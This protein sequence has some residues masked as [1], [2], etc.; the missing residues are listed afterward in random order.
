MNEIAILDFGSQYTHLIAR[1]VRELGVQSSIYQNDVDS[2]KLGYAYGIILSGGPI[3]VIGSQSLDYDKNIF[4]LGVPILGICHGHQLIAKHFGGTVISGQ[5]REYGIANIN[6][7]E[8]NIFNDISD[9]TVWMSH[10]DCVK[11]LPNEELPKEFRLEQ[12]YP[13]P[14]NSATTI[15]FAIQKRFEVSLKIFDLLGKEVETLMDEKLSPGIHKIFFE[16]KG[17]PSGVYFYRLQT[18]GSA[19]TKK[20][21]LLR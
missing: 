8:S 12:N 15:Q 18:G 5:T 9:T 21:I 7:Q 1:R 10:G 16:S 2:K 4:N 19:R 20:L 17:L 6:T 3:S 13:N 14:F 11:Q